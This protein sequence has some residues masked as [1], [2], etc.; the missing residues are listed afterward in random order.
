M[1][2]KNLW[3]RKL[4]TFLT[5]LGIIIGIASVITLVSLGDVSSR[6]VKE[7]V[8]QLGSNSIVVTITG[9]GEETTIPY[10]DTLEWRKIAGVE[11]V[12]PQFRA[13]TTARSEALNKVVS[14]EGVTEGYS[15][16][17]HFFV[18]KGRFIHSIDVSSRQ[19]VAVIGVE[20]ASTLFPNKNPIG[21][22]FF[23]SGELFEVIGLLEEKGQTITGSLDN[24]ILI[25][26]STAERLFGQTGVSLINVMAASEES[27][28]LAVNGIENRLL[29]IFHN[30]TDS[31]MTMTSQDLLKTIDLVSAIMTF[32]LA[33]IAGIS[34]FVAGIG[35]MNIMLVSVTER[36][37][38]IGIRKALGA[39]RRDI[40]ALFL[41]EAI[42]LTT[43][44]GIMGIVLGI[45]SVIGLCDIIGV[46]PLISPTIVITAFFFSLCIGIIFG[47]LPANRAAKLKPIDA[48]KS[49]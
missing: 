7:Q 41:I 26:I 5:M 34:L 36:V 4:R 17:N 49:E 9:R 27:V 29:E 14:I 10:E 13:S 48:L 19:K 37:K 1:A 25:P 21:K 18:Q 2:M 46:T 20:A 38:E 47:I 23:L 32:L 6:T 40:L 39:K 16:V 3:L 33:G 28:D 44:G 43:M 42:V 11:E 12:S 24:T 35:I 45:L 15:V 30:N 22:V 8:N 31:F